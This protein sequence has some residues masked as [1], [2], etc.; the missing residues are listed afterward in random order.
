MFFH[1]MAKLIWVLIFGETSDSPL[2][3]KHMISVFF[4]SL[5]VI[6]LLILLHYEV[7]TRLATG[8]PEI[9]AS[10][11]LQ[12]LIGL[13][14]S[15]LAH[16]AEVLIVA[17]AYHIMIKFEKFGAIML[18]GSHDFSPTFMDC[19]YFSFATYTS[20]GYGDLVPSG[21]LQLLA[22]LEALTGLALI[23]WTASFMFFQMQKNW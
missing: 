7:L 12:A 19:V 9:N 1:G 5:F 17:L 22:S 11:R 15:L 2:S 18:F 10:P 8:L 23:A 13:V 4:I 3:R 14:C 21:P 16:V 20:L 6:G